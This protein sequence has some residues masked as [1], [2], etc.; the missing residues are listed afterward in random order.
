[1]E[2]KK[3][4]QASIREISRAAGEAMHHDCQARVSKVTVQ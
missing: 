1:M 2:E 3:W 4:R